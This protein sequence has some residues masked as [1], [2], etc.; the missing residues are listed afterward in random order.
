MTRLFTVS[1][2][3]A[4]A[5]LALVGCSQPGAAQNAMPMADSH[6]GMPM[7][8]TQGTLKVI[9]PA[10]GSRITS[11]NIPVHVAVSHFKLSSAHV[12]LP[13]AKDEGHIHVMLD[14]M[15]M[16]VL[17]NFYAA[18]HFTLPGQG[19][20][21]GTHTL[22]FDLASNTHMDFEKTV[23]KVTIDYQPT[24]AVALPTAAADAGVPAVA[25]VAP[26]NGATVGPKFT[27]K[28][29][30][31]NFR[32]S[33]ALEGKRDLTGYGHYHV[34]VDMKMPKPG[35]MMS[36]A[37]MIA[38]PGSNTIPVDLSAWKNGTHV[39]TIMP[40]QNDHTEIAG[41]KPAMLTVN[42]QGALAAN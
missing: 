22:I 1:T 3:L 16:G 18:P 37:G 42:L 28:V 15:N 32:P 33:V 26:A 11:T 4:T 14:G 29:R 12:G 2:I 31:T 21:P 5:G 27:I 7:A 6:G 34:F 36:M 9:S 41:A 20:T 8:E 35:E 39:I 13:D 23:Q 30:P 10:N 38:M 25:I 19:I 17:F 24:K 40:V